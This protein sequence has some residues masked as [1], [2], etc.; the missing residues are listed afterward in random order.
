MVVQLRSSLQDTK[1]LSH[2]RRTS[3]FFLLVFVAVL[4]GLILVSATPAHASQNSIGRGTLTLGTC[5]GTGLANG[6]CYR[7]VVSGCPEATADFAATVKINEPADL[8]Q[9]KGTVFFTTG[10]TGTSLY[11]H[12]FEF[13]GDTRCA[14]S[15]CGLLVVQDINAANFRTVQI[16]FVDP[17]RVISEPDGWLTGPATDGPRALA[18]RYATIVHAVWANLL[19][20]DTTHPVCATGNSGGGALIA[21]AMTQYGMG[22]A[23]GPGPMFTFVEPTSAPPYGRIDHGCAGTAAPDLS[24]NCPKGAKISENYEAGTAEA[25]VDPAFPSAV[26]TAD[27]NSNGKNVYASFRHDSVVS[28][29]FAKPSYKT[30]VRMLFGSQDLSAAVPLGSEWYS[31]IKSTKTAACVSGAPHALPE[32]YDGATM[33]VNDVIGGCK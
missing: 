28:D 6:T 7:A 9:L 20:S 15:N 19:Q 25:Y 4:S 13:Q 32:D 8:S 12:D 26:C 33:I 11:D 5:D 16:E 18:C 31:A 22:G 2:K 17:D 14:G 23:S 24:V 29:D 10:G 27:I 1:C 3:I 30:I 21:Y